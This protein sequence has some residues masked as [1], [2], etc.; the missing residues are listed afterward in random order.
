LGALVLL[1]ENAAVLL[2]PLAL[3]ARRAQ[4]ARTLRALGA[5]GLAFTLCLAP[6][7]C[8]NLRAGGVLL[9]TASNAG[10]NFYIGN[11][12]EADGQYRPLVAGRG[13]PD[14][15]REDAARIA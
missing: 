3:A 7:A 2:L 11:A 13:H 8:H 6:V 15:E 5:L 9:P 12:A 1:R 4:P 10:V 14:Y